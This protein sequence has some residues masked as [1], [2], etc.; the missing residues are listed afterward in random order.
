VRQRLTAG[1]GADLVRLSTVV[2]SS[3]PETPLQNENAKIIPSAAAYLYIVIRPLA[4]EQLLASAKLCHGDT[5]TY[6][7]ERPKREIHLESTL[8]RGRQGLT[9]MLWAHPQGL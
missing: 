6:D 5:R 7:K 3:L 4:E 2:A 1:T 9:R 8:K